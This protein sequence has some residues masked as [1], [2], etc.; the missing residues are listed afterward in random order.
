MISTEN[1]SYIAMHLDRLDTEL[2]YG[3]YGKKVDSKSEKKCL[4]ECGCTRIMT[5]LD[6][7]VCKFC[8]NKIHKHQE[9]IITF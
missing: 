5:N 2:L 7:D 1:G 6:F 9:H 8:T 3:T 4:C